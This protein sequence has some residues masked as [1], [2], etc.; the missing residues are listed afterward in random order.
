MKDSRVFAVFRRNVQRKAEFFVAGDV[1]T[2]SPQ[3]RVIVDLSVDPQTHT[4][5][6]VVG[7]RMQLVAKAVFIV[8]FQ[9]SGMAASILLATMMLSGCAS[10][11]AA[12]D[13][14]EAEAVVAAIPDNFVNV[15]QAGDYKPAEWW[16]DFEDP[17]LDDLL[18]T[19]LSNNLTLQEASA[20]LKA[21]EARAR[22]SKSG[23]FP[24][25]NAGL[26]ANYASSVITGLGRIGGE[27]YTPNLGFSYEV[28]LWG[29]LRNEKRAARADALAAAADLQAAKLS[30]M[31][32]T[33]TSYFDLVDARHQVQLTTQIIDVLGDRL[34]RTED[35]YRRGLTSSFELYQVRQEFRNIQSGLPQREAQL[36]AI[37]GQLAVL[38][39]RY[40]NNVAELLDSKL[41]PKLI[42]TSVPA[43][44]PIDLLA[45]RPDIYA[46][47]LRLESAGF[48]AKARRADRFPALNLTAGGG[49]QSSQITGIFDI[50]DKWVLNLGAGLTAPL[51][52]G[53][54]I[55]ANID[56]ADAQYAEQ[57]AIYARMVLTAYQEVGAA[58]ELYEE[59]R[60]RYRFLFAQLEEAE[61]AAGYQAR[62]FSGGVGS[63]I[64][65]LDAQ[66][67]R[68]QVQSSLSAAG[69]DLA[70][71]RLAVHRALGGSWEDGAAQ[72]A[73]PSTPPETAPKPILPEQ[74]AAK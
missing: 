46:Q 33:I 22:I 44:L 8:K 26:D 60:Q 73:K 67:A 59:E 43:G 21:A 20:R 45:Q 49:T 55:T 68:H 71:A 5:L 51:F 15:P 10:I 19:A 30:I 56:L 53:G 25:V 66:R 12:P 27:T 24:Q 28:D 38:A 70:Q 13:A 50:F 54:R 18:Q 57:A 6:F 42:F 16:A 14:S 11:N 32:E 65:F 2:A 4:R 23:L 52:Q 39:G 72:T 64:D 47:G 35:R 74:E 63:Y 48:T 58:M 37:E 9:I 17:V 61:A 31:S 1:G 62:R 7:G 41:Q 29:K 3:P 36:A 69:R 34:D 40:S